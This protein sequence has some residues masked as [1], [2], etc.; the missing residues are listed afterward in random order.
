MHSWLVIDFFGDSRKTGEPGSSLTSTI[1]TQSF[2]GLLFAAVF[3]PEEQGLGVAYVAANLSLSTMLI[4]IGLLGDPKRTKREAADELLVRTA[5]MP[6][7][8]LAIARLLHGAFYL[9]LVST[10]MAIPAGVLCYWACDHR[11]AAVFLYILMATVVAGLLA[12]A[13]AVFARFA[14]LLLGPIRAQLVAGSLK[15]ALLAGGFLGFVACLPHMG[16][17]ADALPM[18]RTGAM[19]WPPY[20]A[21]RV[22]DKPLEAGLFW[23]LLSG[24]ALVLFALATLANRLR[25]NRVQSRPARR[26]LL[27][28]LDRVLPELLEIEE[29]EAGSS[30]VRVAY[31]A[32]TSALDASQLLNVLFGNSSLLPGLSLVDVDF[33]DE[34]LVAF[35]GPR[36]GVAG[37]REA[38]GRD[39]GAL[40]CTALK[41]MGLRPDELARLAAL[42]ARAGIDV[43]K[44]DHGLADH[45]F[46]PWE[47]RVRACQEAVAA[48][49]AR[50]GTRALYAPNLCGAPTEVTRQAALA[51][52]LGARAAMVEPMLAGVG[53]LHALACSSDESL[54]LAHP[55]LGGACAIAPELLL[56]RLFRLFGADAVIYPHHGGRFAYSEQRCRALARRLRET[57][58]PLRPAMPVPAGGMS[59][60]R[61][62]ELLAFYGDDVMLLLGGSLYLAGDELEARARDFVEKVRRGGSPR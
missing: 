47:E 31:P 32:V 23:A 44:D 59:V 39:E 35:G 1:F 37:L 62:D 9:G 48:T 45:P 28:R 5:P 2:I 25:Q 20:W 6:A 17:T 54:L 15:A 24:L 7:G 58:G 36:R 60:E 53:T 12:G 30:L 26:G 11:I 27:S 56:G 16:D 49:N 13:L 38:T 61:V 4:G 3:I 33:P 50:E 40:T 22:V 29:T 57:W 34:M 41:P 21:A 46:C 14:M 19:L 51:S 43:I 52:G 10:G 8:S 18:G 42:F 55:A